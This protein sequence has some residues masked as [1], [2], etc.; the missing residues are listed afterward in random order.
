MTRKILFLLILFLILCPGLHLNC[1]NIKV[2]ITGIRAEKG[3]IVISVFKD[4]E[5]YLK[6]EP[7]VNK[8]FLKEV[9]TDGKMDVQF[10]LEPGIYGLCLLDD[11]NNNEKMEYN[12]LGMPKE[13]F[14]FS[15]YYTSGFTRPKFE[16]FKFTLTENQEKRITIKVRY[17]L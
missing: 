3:Q 15:D 1:Q 4:S 14:G 12:I 10:T 7:F 2:N 11:E 8:I 13:G 6:E 5:S 16:S 17:V 9:V